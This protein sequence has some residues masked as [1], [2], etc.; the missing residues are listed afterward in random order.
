MCGPARGGQLGVNLVRQLT[1]TIERV[2]SVEPS[3][4]QANLGAERLASVLVKG[5]QQVGLRLPET[6][7]EFGEELRAVLGSDNPASSPIGWIR[8][9]LDQ[10]RRLEVI[11][12]VGHHRAVDAEVLG[13]GELA[14]N[15]AVGGRGQYLVAPR[16]AREVGHR[17]VGSRDVGPK[18][19]AQTPSQVVGQ[20]V[21]T[22]A[23]TADFFRVTRGLVH[24]V[25]IRP[26]GR[27][28]AP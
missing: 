23:G 5:G 4:E 8:A 17:P 25:I 11:E 24:A 7:I 22:A 9:A 18:H 2:E 14:P 13:Q 1:W 19:S 21:V 28:V 27:S 6:P 3:G 20:R 16:T 12:E 10:L 26:L 15:G